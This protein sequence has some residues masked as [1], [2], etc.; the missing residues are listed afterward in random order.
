MNDHNSGYT[1]IEIAMVLAIIGLLLGGIVKG[2][3]LINNTK[4]KNLAADFTN[5]PISIYG[6]QDKFHSYPG[7]D[8]AATIHLTAP[9]GIIIQPGNGN[10]TINGNW[11][12]TITQNSESFN[13]WQQLRLGG[14]YQ[15]PI[16]TTDPRYIPTNAVGGKIGVTNVLA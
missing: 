6:Y 7:D 8:A 5:I 9:T 13:F 14:F 2:Q 4:V 15:G 3:E 12:D 16:D 11:N 1:L 10:G